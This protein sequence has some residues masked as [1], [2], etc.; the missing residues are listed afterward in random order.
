MRSISPAELAAALD[1]QADV[2][3]SLA[4]ALRAE[5]ATPAAA[6]LPH[7]IAVSPETVAPTLLT[8]VDAAKSLGVSRRTLDRL[9]KRGLPC[10]R[11]GSRV[12]Y[13]PEALAEWAARHEEKT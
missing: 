6:G 7:Q 11:V 12:M 10:V 3:A 13:R 1:A 4:A 9:N 8:P 2:L 5:P